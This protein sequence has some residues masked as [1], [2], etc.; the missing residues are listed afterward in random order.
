LIITRDGDKMSIRLVEHLSIKGFAFILLTLFLV[1]CGSATVGS[2]VGT[3]VVPSE[4]SRPARFTFYDDGTYGF[5][6]PP[7][8]MNYHPYSAGKWY[9]T[10]DSLFVASD[11]RD[12]LLVQEGKSDSDSI[13][14]WV[15][16]EGD[17]WDYE[18]VLVV[19]ND[20][21]RLIKTDTNGFGSCPRQPIDSM[22][23]AYLGGEVYLSPQRS[24]QYI[25]SH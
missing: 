11:K 13:Q 19:W 23:I 10:E 16:V 7:G 8:L 22:T 15:S 17:L 3:Y 18:V 5:S 25:I 2:I 21:R 1:S 24:Y 6:A 9:R 4:D 12:E 14:F 20:G